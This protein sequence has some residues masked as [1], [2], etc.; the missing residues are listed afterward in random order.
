MN[1]PVS[2]FKNSIITEKRYHK[3]NAK[4]WWHYGKLFLTFKEEV[5][6]FVSTNSKDNRKDFPVLWGHHT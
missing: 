2:I 5:I 6:P 1:G 4:P 3:V